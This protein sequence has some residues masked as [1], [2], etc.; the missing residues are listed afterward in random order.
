MQAS[1]PIDSPAAELSDGTLLYQMLLAALTSPRP[2]EFVAINEPETSL[3]ADLLA[4]LARLIAD[5]ATRGQ[6][7]VVTRAQALVEALPQTRAFRLDKAFG[8]TVIADSE[9]PQWIW[10]SR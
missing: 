10:L 2:P 1:A 9:R 5:A 4:P 8:E 6:I 3:H 7:L